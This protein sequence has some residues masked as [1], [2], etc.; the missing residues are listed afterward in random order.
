MPK[1]VLTVLTR[2]YFELNFSQSG[3]EAA[4]SHKNGIRRNYYVALNNTKEN[5]FKRQKGRS[6]ILGK[7]FSFNERLLEV[8]N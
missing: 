2:G 6:F 1:Q 5:C 7:K 8:H 4:H 3:V